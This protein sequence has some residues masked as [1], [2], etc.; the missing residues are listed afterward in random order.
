VNV[1]R[2]ALLGA[3]LA[4]PVAARFRP[5]VKPAPFVVDGRAFFLFSNVTPAML[6]YDELDYAL[7][8]APGSQ[9]HLRR[10]FETPHHA[11]QEGEPL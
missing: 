4:L 11:P 9:R 7:G 10:T 5:F 6:A 2:R 3:F 1:S 8:L